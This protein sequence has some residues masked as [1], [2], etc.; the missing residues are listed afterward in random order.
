MNNHFDS[1]ADVYNSVWHFS[2]DYKKWMLHNILIA[3]ELNKDDI[4][5]DIGGGT[6]AY[7]EL[8]AHKT[9]LKNKPYCVEPSIEMSNI[10]KKNTDVNVYNE[11]GNKFS[12]RSLMYDKVLLKEVIHHI[13]DRKLLW[14]NLNNHINKKG[15]ILIVTRPQK[16]KLPLFDAAKET[17]YKNQPPYEKFVQELSKASFDVDVKID[18][19][20]LELD[21]EVWFNM[22][23]KRF[24]SDL[25]K[26]TDK[27]I[28]YGVNEIK[29][30]IEKE[31]IEIEDVIIYITALK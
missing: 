21:K 13:K 20:T 16:I 14:C 29:H 15:R 28:E 22:I 23:R 2:N 17:F 26:F 24:M 9:K 18:S 27:E 4:L 5:V 10:A 7:T 25:A 1:I 6:G 11:D 30:N 19:Y 3:L 12:E 8:I 31:K